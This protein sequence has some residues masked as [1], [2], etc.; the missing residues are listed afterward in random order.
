MRGA[1]KL[2]TSYFEKTTSCFTADALACVLACSITVN[3]LAR[4]LIHSYKV[5][6]TA[7]ICSF[8]FICIEALGKQRDEYNL[9]MVSN[10]CDKFLFYTRTIAH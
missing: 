9:V 7:V 6:D 5:L 2:L 8:F 3:Q 4:V 10:E 1:Y